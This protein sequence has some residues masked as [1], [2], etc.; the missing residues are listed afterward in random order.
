LKFLNPCHKLMRVSWK[1]SLTSSLSFENMKHTV[2]MVF[3]CSRTICS[4]SF[5]FI[6]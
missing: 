5:S 6:V 1:R 4:N 2:Y 3:L